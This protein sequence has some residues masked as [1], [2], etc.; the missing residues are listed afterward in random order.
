MKLPEGV[1]PRVIE[2]LEPRYH[3]NV[4]LIA[5]HKVGLHNKIVFTKAKSL[6]DDYYLSYDTI[7]KYPIGTNGKIKCYE[8]PVDELIV[9]ESFD[10]GC[11]LCGADQMTA[12]CNN[13]NCS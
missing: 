8:V 11:Q 1:T 2:I 10:T 7:T 13:A 3:D 12:N 6:P 4:V 5:K 9:L